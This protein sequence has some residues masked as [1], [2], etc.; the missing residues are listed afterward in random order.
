MQLLSY[1][2]PKMGSQVFARRHIGR[3]RNL[4]KIDL[5]NEFRQHYSQIMTPLRPVYLLLS[6]Y[7]FFSVEIL[8]ILHVLDFSIL[9]IHDWKRISKE[10]RYWLAK[11]EKLS[12]LLFC[13]T[14]PMHNNYEVF[15][16]FVTLNNSIV[17]DLT[18]SLSN[19]IPWDHAYFRACL[20][21]GGDPDRWGN[22]AAACPYNSHFILI[23]LTGGLPGL[24]GRVYLSQLG[25]RFA[26]WTC[27]GGVTR[28]PG[29][30]LT[31]HF[32][33]CAQGAQTICSIRNLKDLYGNITK[34]LFK[35][36]YRE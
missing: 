30:R 3:P 32:N 11:N 14:Q 19:K 15:H 21:G 35:A 16:W 24:A 26:M 33:V 20:H 18:V 13:S 28:P 2:I 31:K 5:R 6:R 34:F 22:P 12:A 27:Q 25:S 4:C 29:V 9:L 36:K 7:N 17:F 23:T 8:P 10:R 1:E